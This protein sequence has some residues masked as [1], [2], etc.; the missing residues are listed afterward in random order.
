[1][2]QIQS[3][4]SYYPGNILCNER[5]LHKMRGNSWLAKQL[6]AFEKG[7]LIILAT[8]PRKFA[9]FYMILDRIN[10]PDRRTF[11]QVNNIHLKPIPP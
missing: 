6:S 3:I 1:V 10:T 9:N 4:F 8:S 2:V 7:K 5:T 11:L